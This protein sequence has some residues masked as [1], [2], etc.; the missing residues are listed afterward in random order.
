MFV[1]YLLTYRFIVLGANRG[2]TDFQ[3]QEIVSVMPIQKHML[4]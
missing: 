1:T 4:D 2:P 3:C